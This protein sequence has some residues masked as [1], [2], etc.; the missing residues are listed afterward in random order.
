MSRFGQAEQIL[1]CWHD[2]DL[3]SILKCAKI[4]R[5]HDSD[6]FPVFTFYQ[7]FQISSFRQHG[8]PEVRTG[9]WY[10]KTLTCWQSWNSDKISKLQDFRITRFGRVQALEIVI[11]LQDVKIRACPNC[12]LDPKI[13]SSLKTFKILNGSKSANDDWIVSHFKQPLLCMKTWIESRLRESGDS[14]CGAQI[15]EFRIVQ[16]SKPPAQSQPLEATSVFDQRREVEPTVPLDRDG[17]L[18]GGRVVPSFFLESV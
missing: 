5:F 15:F 3:L 14:S 9:F 12:W 8:H 6:G 10:F 11:I 4:S 18:V 17:E 2:F 16:W 13:Y 7:S 1:T